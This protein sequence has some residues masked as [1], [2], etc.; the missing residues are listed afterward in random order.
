MSILARSASRRWQGLALGSLVFVSF[1]AQPCFAARWQ[2]VGRPSD[3]SL[4]LAYIDMDS[5]RQEGDFRVATFLTVYAH[6][7]TNSHGYKIDRIGQQTAFDCNNHGV[8]LVYTIGYF[9]GKEIGRSSGTG[10]DWKDN[11]SALPKDVY[12]TRAF[13][14]TCNAPLA[15][16]PEPAPAASDE[17]A[18]VNLPAEPKK[19]DY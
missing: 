8:A 15:P 13:D 7:L 3:G 11:M 17:P 5:I 16:M 1:L 6:A 14:I 9:E 18:T 10:G 4:A 2:V 12:S 19:R